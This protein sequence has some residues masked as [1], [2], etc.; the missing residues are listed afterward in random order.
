MSCLTATAGL[1][2][3]DGAALSMILLH[4]HVLDATFFHVSVLSPAKGELCRGIHP[5]PY[6]AT[7]A[8]LTAATFIFLT[9]VCLS[10]GPTV[11]PGIAGPTSTD[12]FSPSAPDS[13]VVFTS[14]ISATF[15]VTSS[16]LMRLPGLIVIHACDFLTRFADF[17][18][19]R[20][21]FFALCFVPPTQPLGQAMMLVPI[22][23]TTVG[24]AATSVGVRQHL[25]RFVQRVQAS[26]PHAVHIFASM[27]SVR[28][29]DWSGG[30]SQAMSDTDDVD[31]IP[32]GAIVWINSVLSGMAS[33]P[34]DFVEECLAWFESRLLGLVVTSP[35]YVQD[36]FRVYGR[37]CLSAGADAGLVP[38]P[39]F[40]IGERSPPLP[41]S[42]RSIAVHCA[43]D[44]APAASSSLLLYHLSLK[45]LSMWPEPVNVGAGDASSF[46]HLF[47]VLLLY[48]DDCL[49]PVTGDLYL[50]LVIGLHLPSWRGTLFPSVAYPLLSELYGAAANSVA[51][52][53]MDVS[54]S[55]L[56]RDRA[57]DVGK[58]DVVLF[59]LVTTLVAEIVSDKRLSPVLNRGLLLRG[60]SAPLPSFPRPFVLCD[61][62]VPSFEGS[63]AY[64]YVG[65]DNQLQVCTGIGVAAAVS[66]WLEACYVCDA[67]LI[68]R[69]FL[70]GDAG[71]TNPLAKYA[72][73]ARMPK[74]V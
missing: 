45:Q 47:A 63:D 60:G 19:G 1:P 24:P 25:R 59:I 64:G 22:V 8:R 10:A 61:F 7:F 48:A 44:D 13:R 43:S 65:P 33:V 69:E 62:A 46:E 72:S 73:K 29:E 17:A 5:Q 14:Q 32:V 50:H 4:A 9:G 16:R 53:Y 28:S 39:A 67:A 58:D 27:A 11:L 20:L 66:A 41:D 55:K 57:S 42:L 35:E 71:A 74:A 40:S 30:H 52:P 34:P 38:L 26:R 15:L 56:L 12:H 18:R 23:R 31:C 68:V 36:L 2:A 21:Q 6:F 37:L 54:V 70:I 3:W 49:F 51:R